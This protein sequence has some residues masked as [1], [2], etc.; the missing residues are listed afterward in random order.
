M[1]L[2]QEEH[3]IPSKVVLTDVKHNSK[4]SDFIYGS[5][6]G[7]T[8][9]IV[10][11]PF[12]TIKVHMQTQA[13]HSLKDCVKSIYIKEGIFGFFRGISAPLLGSMAENAVIFLAYNNMQNIIKDYKYHDRNHSLNLTDLSFAGG[14]SGAVVSFVLTPIELIKC[15][16]QMQGYLKKVSNPYFSGPISLISDTFKKSGLKGLYKG[17]TGTLL[18]EIS[19]GVA[20]FGVYELSIKKL[21]EHSANCTKKSDLSPLKVMG[22]GALA[23]MSYN[24][25]LYPADVVKSRMQSGLHP[26]RGFFY[27]ALDIYRNH[28]GL[29]FFR[30]FG[31]TIA[32]SAPSSGI[33]FLTYEAMTRKFSS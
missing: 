5:V 19:G 1:Q 18:R 23:G 32:R 2:G 20:W 22:A 17:H 12:D 27:S 14:V 29:F 13:S 24:A 26:N 16:L 7:F 21:I 31:L 28:G 11:Y 15:Q 4:F 3:I 10:E 6:S 33:I 30:G 8:G 25:A 9:K